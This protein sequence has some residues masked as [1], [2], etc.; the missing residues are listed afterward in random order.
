MDLSFTMVI[1]ADGSPTLYIPELKEHYHSVNGAVAESMHVFIR[2]GLDFMKPSRKCLS[3]LEVGMGTGLNV[4]LTFHHRAG[5]EI[6]Y[7]ALEPFPLNEAVLKQLNYSKWVDRQ[8]F[9]A[10]HQSEWNTT[11][12]MSEKYQKFSLTKL[13][14]TVQNFHAKR[15]FDLIYYDAFAP[16]AQPELWTEAV[17]SKLFSMTSE[18]GALVT[19]CAKGSVRRALVACGFTLESLPGAAGKREMTRAKKLH[20]R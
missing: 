18:G 3:I 5:L 14:T 19:Y 12:S 11:L 13:K 20:Y 10:V 8:I 17:F 7:T 16:H 9:S 6:S 4:C 2:N 1:T 15:K